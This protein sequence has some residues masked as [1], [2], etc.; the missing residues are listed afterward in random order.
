[1]KPSRPADKGVWHYLF[2][3][4]KDTKAVFLFA[5]FINAC[6]GLFITFQNLV[7]KYLIDDILLVRN[8]T[9]ED[10][11]R[12]LA[13]LIVLYLICSVFGRMLV[14]HW[15]YRIFTR[16]R[17][18]ILL[19]MRS[20]FFRHINSLCLRFHNRHNSGELYSYLFGSP[21]AQIQQYLHQFSLMGPGAVFTLV[22][23]LIWVGFWD[24]P[25]TL[26]LGCSVLCSVL[27][28]N[29]ARN[30]MKG[31]HKDFQSAEGSVTGRVAD[32]I[33]GTREIKLYSI[34]DKIVQD[35]Q[36]QAETIS[37]KS[38]TRDIRSHMQFMKQETAGYFF[39]AMLCALG[40][41]RYLHHGLKE[42]ELLAYLACFSALQA[43]LQ[44]LFQIAALKG[45]ALASLERI[46]AV[47]DTGSTTPDPA[48][49]ILHLP[50]HGDIEFRNVHF[51]YT[52]KSTLQNL[53][54]TIPYGQRIA[55]VG[56]SGAGK[57]T[58]VQLLL[59]LYDPQQGEI[60]IGKV[61][62]QSCLGADVRRYFGVVPQ[63]PYFFQD[64][65]RE[66]LKL[67]RQDADENQIRQAC[68]S[69]NAWEFIEKLP[70]GLDTPLG[71][72]GA[73]I[74]GGQRQRLAI[75]R[76]LLYNPP[77]FI[78]DEATSALDT[79]SERLI[80]EALQQS[81]QGKTAIFIAH[82]LATIKNCDR[83][84]VL[85]DGQ[86]IQDGSYQALADQPGLFQQMLQSDLKASGSGES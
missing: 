28:M 35:F 4:L 27:I 34:E 2:P 49:N 64:S 75:A 71:E 81:I 24:I 57:S 12:R 23:S 51:S 41:W 58:I 65:I 36:Q 22:S 31:L 15:S 9:L 60:S 38:I 69:A 30:Q 67:V 66:N 7:P 86:I 26:L 68:L 62:L 45:T 6:H 79:L 53:N 78:F 85:Q 74:S 37:Q 59:R 10:R 43:P 25:M 54:L 73:S 29:H 40:A 50:A 42:G 63:S 14:W 56:P 61:P 77:F 48:D 83:I 8:I 46:Q 70:E 17:E 39:F 19:S 32:L 33:R 3:Y 55:L 44:Q 18:R 5:I 11:Y 47:L 76:I 1:M 16:V 20:R 82:R 21:L 80:Q 84:L 13:L 72:G 52:T